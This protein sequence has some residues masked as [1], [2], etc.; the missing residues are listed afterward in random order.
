MD[1]VMGNYLVSIIIPSFNVEKYIAKCLRSIQKQTYRNIEII[2]VDDKSLD[3][4]VSVINQIKSKDKRIN[5]I[6]LDEN[7]GVSYAR[8]KGL[9]NTKGE[10]VTFVDADDYYT[11]RHA[12]EKVVDIFQ[13][14]DVDCVMFDYKTI[15]RYGLALR[16]TIPFKNGKYS[17]GQIAEMKIYNDIPHWH[18]VWNKCYKLNKVKGH[19]RF[20]EQLSC[21]EDV[22]FNE[23]FLAENPNFYLMGHKYFYAYNCMNAGQITRSINDNDIDYVQQFDELIEE[24]QRTLST[25]KLVN[26]SKKAFVGVYI[27]YFRKIKE[28]R[29]IADENDD[30]KDLVLR[31]DNNS[32]YQSILKEVRQSDDYEKVNSYNQHSRLQNIKR[33]LKKLMK[34]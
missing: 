34:L 33:I 24:F 19:I 1:N 16:K 7:L 17:A 25:Y 29:R 14:N 28:I 12:L 26:A 22:R 15:H 27:K 2:V 10:L 23:D 30:L 32:T 3:N 21:A 18:Y 13:K 20:N 8:Q 11:D 6:C 31:I 4:T 9:E 5:L